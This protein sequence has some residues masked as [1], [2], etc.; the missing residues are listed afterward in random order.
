M[1]IEYPFIYF[2]NFG[3]KPILIVTYFI[4]IYLFFSQHIFNK[5]Y[6][7]FDIKRIVEPK[8]II[9]DYINRKK[10]VLC[11]GI[12]FF[13]GINYLLPGDQ[14]ILNVPIVGFANKF[15]VC[16][17]ML[18][19]ILLFTFIAGDFIIRKNKFVFFNF[20][21]NILA[22]LMLTS[23]YFTLIS[24][25]VR[26]Y[27]YNVIAL[28]MFFLIAV[29]LLIINFKP[30]NN[31]VTNSENLNC[32]KPVETYND[33][34]ELNKKNAEKIKNIIVSNK[35]EPVCLCVSGEWGTGKTSVINGV[36]DLVKREKQ[37]TG[38]R[39]DLIITIN[40]LEIDDI[41]NLFRYF[42]NNVKKYL[43]DQG[44]YNGIS[45]EYQNFIAASVGTITNNKFFDYFVSKMFC[46]NEEYRKK[47]GE[48]NTLLSEVMKEQ[49]IIVIVDDIERCTSEKALQFIFFVSEIA[50]FSNCVSI[51][52]T[53]Y[54]KLLVTCRVNDERFFEKF[55][56]Y[57]ININDS[58]IKEMVDTFEKK[59]YINQNLKNLLDFNIFS[60]ID[61]IE[62]KL[63]FEIDKVKKEQQNS[64]SDNKIIMFKQD[65]LE[66]MKDC[67]MLSLKNP[68]KMGKLFHSYIRNCETLAREYDKLLNNN[69]ISL[70]IY[71]KKIQL[72]M[73]IFLVSFIEVCL[74]QEYKEI[75][76]KDLNTLFFEIDKLV[77]GDSIYSTYL[78]VDIVIDKALLFFLCKSRLFDLSLSVFES[79]YNHLDALK[80][81]ENMIKMPTEL[82]RIVNGYTTQ[83][84]VWFSAIIEKNLIKYKDNAEQIYSAILKTFT[85]NN[86]SE[87]DKYI[88]ILFEFEACNHESKVWTYVFSQE[89]IRFFTGKLNII[90]TFYKEIYMKSSRVFEEEYINK[91]NMFSK[92]YIYDK[93]KTIKNLLYYLTDEKFTKDN[94]KEIHDEL[95]AFENVEN[96]VVYFLDK[97]NQ[98]I[99]RNKKDDTL[100]YKDKLKVLSAN[101][102]NRI[103][104]LRITDFPD[105]QGAL[106][107]M[108]KDIIDITLFVEIS[109]FVNSRH[110]I[111]F[112]FDESTAIDMGNTKKFIDF[113]MG[114]LEKEATYLSTD[115]INKFTQYFK[116]LE[117][118]NNFYLDDS[119]FNQL[120]GL[121]TKFAEKSG[122]ST[123]WYR[124]VLIDKIVKM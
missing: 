31:C 3:I 83:E 70:K 18:S 123:I 59:L 107:D 77:R 48:L 61:T 9:S 68:R 4:L 16:E 46:T 6:F 118:C 11:V 69:D 109:E 34:F 87:G 60:C 80:F 51:F 113:F 56:N 32:F 13:S 96:S 52:A 94:L 72:G 62:K 92:M 14:N 17:F 88:Q 39:E 102:N 42:F 114:E 10:L 82:S 21:N 45:S 76:K 7:K 12:L 66:K 112:A 20:L 101:I 95:Y 28:I 108:D 33:L 103:E 27:W 99:F 93:F 85:Y 35:S 105:V 44:V 110:N 29:I 55:F 30:F 122:N 78:D 37:C 47:K 84:Q 2:G 64:S 116:N 74:P 71:A 1:L 40:A 75:Q 15:L 91:F 104:C 43:K 98:E 25:Q 106:S 97:I 63:N 67:F 57:R 79:D 121:V 38:K 73:R 23:M 119:D 41:S 36:I 81:I 22:I 8:K 53:D 120:Q 5:N 115:L 90:R 24:H 117:E 65:K 58:N 100:S 50:T 26:S 111:Y 124:K 19:F 89:Y 54:D 86:T 49:K